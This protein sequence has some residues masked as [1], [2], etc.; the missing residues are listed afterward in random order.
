MWERGSIEVICPQY[1]STICLS[2]IPERL[3]YWALASLTVLCRVSLLLLLLPLLFIMQMVT[4]NYACCCSGSLIHEQNHKPRLKVNQKLKLKLSSNLHAHLIAIWPLYWKSS[5]HWNM[6]RFKSRDCCW[7]EISHRW[8]LFDGSVSQ[9]STNWSQE[10]ML[11][12]LDWIEEQVAIHIKE[13]YLAERW[14]SSSAS[15]RKERSCTWICL[16]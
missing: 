5:R 6:L 12:H 8:T 9:L 15:G 10:Q 2:F 7:K 13:L 1:S 14:A 11:S 3:L 4:H 16:I